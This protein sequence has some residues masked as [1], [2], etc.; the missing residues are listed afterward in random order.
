MTDRRESPYTSSDD[1]PWLTR[2]GA[3]YLHEVGEGLHRW[4]KGQKGAA[5]FPSVFRAA[6]AILTAGPCRRVRY[7]RMIR[8]VPK[9]WMPMTV[10]GL[11]GAMVKRGWRFD[12]GPAAFMRQVRSRTRSLGWHMLALMNLQKMPKRLVLREM[13]AAHKKRRHPPRAQRG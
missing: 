8:L 3:F 9:G 13:A 1:W 11:I 10:R 7:A 12:R 2:S 5:R 4:R 6:C